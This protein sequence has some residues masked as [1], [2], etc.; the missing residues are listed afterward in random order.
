MRIQPIIEL[1][2]NQVGKTIKARLK[3]MDKSQGWLAEKAS[4]SNNAVSK[5]IKTGKISLE[6]AQLAAECLE[7]TLDELLAGGVAEVTEQAPDDTLERLNSEEAALVAEYRRATDA[8]RLMM[9]AQA[10]T[11]PKRL[12]RSNLRS[13][14]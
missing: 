12:S 8:G 13:R 5:W 10:R 1:M 4:V 6:K 14:N 9:Q 7:V 11:V 3:L 2:D